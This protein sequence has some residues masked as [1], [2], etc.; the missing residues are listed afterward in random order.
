METLTDSLNWDKA[1]LWN[2]SD[3]SEVSKILTHAI[4]TKK[5][6]YIF[7]LLFKF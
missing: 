6:V 1:D 5:F 3:T 4:R 2:K 7:V